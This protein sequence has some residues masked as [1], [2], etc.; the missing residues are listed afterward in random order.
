MRPGRQHQPALRLATGKDP[1]PPE[2]RRYPRLWRFCHDPGSCSGDLQRSRK[3]HLICL[4]L[5]HSTSPGHP[6]HCPAAGYQ[7]QWHPGCW[8]SHH[9]DKGRC[10]QHLQF[11]S[12]LPGWQPLL[13]VP[14]SV[15]GTAGH[16]PSGLQPFLLQQAAWRLRQWHQ[17][18]HRYA[19]QRQ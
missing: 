4:R 2:R 8:L 9:R 6:C 18:Q 10:L 14:C 11:Q 17:H 7:G 5:Q 15:P 12:A 13:P 19:R 16:K 3:V 1:A